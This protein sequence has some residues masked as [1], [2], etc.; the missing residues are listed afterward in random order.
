[1]TAL[2][3]LFS[4]EKHLKAAIAIALANVAAP[5]KIIRLGED[6]LVVSLPSA[7][8]R[9]HKLKKGDELE[10]EEAGPRLVL[11]PKSAAVSGRVSVDVSGTMPVTKRIVVALYKAG[12]DEIEVKFGNFKELETAQNTIRQDFVGFEV[13][14]K[15]KQ[16]ILAKNVSEQKHEEFDTLLRR[17]F[18]LL[19]EMGS[20]CYRAVAA[21]NFDELEAIAKMDDDVNRHVNFCRRTLNTIGHRVVKRVAPTYYLVEQLERTGDCYKLFCKRVSEARPVPKK[22]MNDL[23]ADANFFVRRFYELYYKFSLHDLA[24]LWK[25]KEKI[26]KNIASALEAAGKKELAAVFAISEIVSNIADANGALLTAR[27]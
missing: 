15:T 8:T 22:W 17:V 23:L 5:R 3:L 10:V 6:T 16:I 12:Y 14:S 20:E 4:V 11:Y 26:E 9:Q 7:W 18:M 1:M 27:L 2:F 24:E 13:I 21:G 19:L 25:E